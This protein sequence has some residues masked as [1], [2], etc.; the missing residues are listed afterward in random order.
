MQVFIKTCGVNTTEFKIYEVIF[1]E[2]DVLDKFTFH[3]KMNY[4]E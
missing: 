1:L 4:T 2:F 3:C